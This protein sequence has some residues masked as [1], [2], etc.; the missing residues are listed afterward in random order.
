MTNTMKGEAEIE[1]GASKFVLRYDMNA[2]AELEHQLDGESIN[3]IMVDASKRVGVRFL[4][5]AI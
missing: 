1:L 2:I 3:Y 4:R 5:A